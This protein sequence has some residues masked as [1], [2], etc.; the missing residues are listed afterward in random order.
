MLPED[1]RL[2][3]QAKVL[4]VYSR[5]CPVLQVKV[6]LRFVGEGGCGRALLRSIIIVA[7][8]TGLRRNELFTLER[9]NLGFDQRAIRAVFNSVYG[10]W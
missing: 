5:T 3:K 1:K 4:P 2:D 7:A 6:S 10:F 9:S 8:D